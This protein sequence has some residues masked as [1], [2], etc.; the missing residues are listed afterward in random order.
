LV[1][2]SQD[3]FKNAPDGGQSTRGAELDAADDEHGESKL[4][5]TK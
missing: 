4:K 3:V 2:F 5:Q 1:K